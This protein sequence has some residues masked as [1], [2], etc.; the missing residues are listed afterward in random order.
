[1]Q[2]YFP[3]V[4]SPFCTENRVMVGMIYDFIKNLYCF[5]LF[6]RPAN[7]DGECWLKRREISRLPLPPPR[8]RA[9]RPS[10]PTHHRQTYTTMGYIPL[11]YTT[12]TS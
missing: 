7:I 5:L 2:N 9:R 3:L 4:T 11:L 6:T 1:M 8:P 12:L 10:S